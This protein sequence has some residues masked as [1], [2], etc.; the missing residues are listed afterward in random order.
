MK[1][2]TLTLATFITAVLITSC[3]S[4]EK[5]VENAKEEAVEA[6]VNLN[7]ANEEYM[8]DMET[9]RKATNEKIEAN[10]N[11][12]AEF[13]KRI[14]NEKKEAKADYTKR[15]DELEK[16]NSD[17]KKKMDDYKSDGKANWEAFKAEFGRD[18]DELGEAIRSFGE[19]KNK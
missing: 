10:N 4:S 17:I 3:T 8:A 18:M 13:K 6:A 19:K 2:S 15:I 14:E 11:S 16:K 12:I 7:N 1:K 5:K 9:Y